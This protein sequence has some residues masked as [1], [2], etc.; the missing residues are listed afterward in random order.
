M[1]HESGPRGS[2]GARQ[3]GDSKW[4]KPVSAKICGFLRFPAKICGFL[5]FSVQIC[6]SQIPWF[7]ERAENLR[8]CAFRVRFLPFAVSLLARPDSRWWKLEI[9]LGVK[10]VEDFR[11]QVFK[12]IFPIKNGLENYHQKTSPHSSPQEKKSV[13]KWGRQWPQSEVLGNASLFTIFL[14]TT[15]VPLKP[16]PLP[17]QQSDDFLLNLYPDPPTL[18]FL[19]KARETPKKSKGSSLRGTPKILG[20]ERKNA[21]KSKGNRK[22]KKARKSKKARIGGSGNLYWKDLKQNCEHSPKIANSPEIANKQNL[23]N[24]QNMWKQ[25]M[26]K[27]TAFVET[28]V[29]TSVDTLVGR[30]VGTIVGSPWRAKT[31]KWTFVGTLVGALVGVFV[32]PLVGPLVDPLVGSNFAVRVLCACLRILNKRAFLNFVRA[33]ALQKCGSEK[34]PRFSLPKVSWNLAWNFGEV[35]RATFSRVWACDGKFHQISRQKRCEKRK[36]SRK[37][38]SAGAQRWILVS[39]EKW[40]EIAEKRK[41]KFLSGRLKTFALWN[42]SDRGNQLQAPEPRKNQSSSKVTKKWLSGGSPKVA[43]KWPQKWLFYPKRDSKVS[44]F[45]GHFWA[46]LGEPPESHFLVTFE[47]LW[48]FRGSGACSW[49]P[50]SENLFCFFVVSTKHQPQWLQRALQAT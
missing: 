13:E 26:W 9:P 40:E 27:L 17:N 21:Q 20:K 28:F 35:F 45:W 22:T 46:T 4:E 41:E 16:P 18:P 25:D 49:F 10:N 7:T 8:K 23:G 12:P 42:F 39:L 2:I 37:F 15:L 31:G 34:F 44:H 30:F 5:R 1:L 14:F 38:H 33:V 6:D 48:F 47:L 50:R 19:K 29:G 24:E 11:W 43:Q 3:K 32:G 36:I